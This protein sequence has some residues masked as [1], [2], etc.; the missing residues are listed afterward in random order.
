MR[1]RSRHIARELATRVG[2]AGGPLSGPVAALSGGNQQ[3]VL[4]G[5]T[6]QRPGTVVLALDEPT[7]GV[8]VGGRGEIHSLIRREAATGVAVI[9]A[10]TELDEVLELAELVVTMFEGTV[11]SVVRA[12]EASSAAVLEDMTTRRSALPNGAAA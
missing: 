8:D 4:L 12:A 6:L 1:R 10:S 5:R 7:R 2:L 9:F 11:V 3:K